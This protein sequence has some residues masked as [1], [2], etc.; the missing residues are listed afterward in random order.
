MECK[1]HSH[2][3]THKTKQKNMYYLWWSAEGELRTLI[4]SGGMVA[5]TF[6]SLA[7]V[8]QG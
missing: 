2:H 6:V 8:Q 7:R 5:D 1:L 3:A 4:A